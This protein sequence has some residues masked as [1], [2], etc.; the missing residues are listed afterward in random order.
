MV[1]RKRLFPLHTHIF[2][3]EIII[4]LSEVFILNGGFMGDLTLSPFGNEKIKR[5]RK[6]KKIENGTI[7][8]V[9]LP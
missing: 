5:T 9:S 7:S 8:M 4:A 3:K 6:K 2:L 1:R